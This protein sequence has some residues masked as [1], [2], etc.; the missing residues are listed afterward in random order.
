[1]QI[2]REKCT[3][4]EACHMYCAVEAIH[5]SEDESISIINQDECVECGVCYRA[6]VC[7]TD[8]IYPEELKWPR[9]LRG[10][11]SDPMTVHKDTGLPGRGTEEMKTNDVT[12]RFRHGYAGVAI[13]M[14]R[15]GVATRFRDVDIMTQAIAKLGVSF[16]PQNPLTFLMVDQY[17]GKTREDILNERVMSAIIECSVEM[18]RLES[19]LKV[20][21]ETA[22]K[23]DTVFSLDLICRVGEKGEIKTLPPAKKIGFTPRRNTKNNIGYGRP[24]AKED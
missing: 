10:F 21:K 20:I 19:L 23:L 17:T 14:G 24:L 8:A 4:C 5:S 22:P 12:G 3:G 16:E 13:E 6:K 7:P 9:S 18:D 2:D 11:F 15:P 1:M